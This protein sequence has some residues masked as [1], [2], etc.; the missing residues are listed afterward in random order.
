MVKMKQIDFSVINTTITTM[1]NTKPHTMLEQ[2][3]YQTTLIN[4]L[5]NIAEDLNDNIN[6]VA[7]GLANITTITTAE[8]DALFN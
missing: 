6:E 2:M 4:E 3:R 7:D 1:N 5:D 8:I